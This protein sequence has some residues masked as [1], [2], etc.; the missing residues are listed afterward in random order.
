MAVAR[1]VMAGVGLCA[2][3]ACTDGGGAGASM[4]VVLATAEHAPRVAVP[5]FWRGAPPGDLGVC[6]RIDGEPGALGAAIEPAVLVITGGEIR[7]GAET[8]MRLPPGGVPELSPAG[9]LGERLTAAVKRQREFLDAC[10][11]AEAPIDLMVAAAPD[12]PAETLT[13]ALH[14]SGKAGVTRHFLAVAGTGGAPWQAE[15]FAAREEKVVLRWNDGWQMDLGDRRP[16]RIP[17]ASLAALAD[18]VEPGGL[19]CA[20]LPLYAGPWSETVGALDRMA[21]L[22]ARRFLIEAVYARAPVE[23]RVAGQ[24]VELRIGGSVGAFPLVP[25]KFIDKATV[26]N[27]TYDGFNGLHPCEGFFVEKGPRR[28]PPPDL[29]QLQPG[30]GEQDPWKGLDQSGQ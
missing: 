22:G 20:T 14:T 7:L 2:V 29:S 15:G 28:E 9:P 13:F 16:P 23:A 26:T 8:V 27:W 18:Y 10:G 30:E 19:G 12:V 5:W 25:M 11:R 3:V 21:S 1:G 4:R 6:A 17:L 24:E